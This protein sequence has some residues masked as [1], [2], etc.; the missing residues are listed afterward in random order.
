MI[1]QEILELLAAWWD[2]P[3]TQA[4]VDR[5]SEIIEQAQECDKIEPY[6]W[7]DDE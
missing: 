6:E 3:E 7:T 5:L 1:S 4:A 2:E